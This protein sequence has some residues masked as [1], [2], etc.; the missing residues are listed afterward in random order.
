MLLFSLINRNAFT[1]SNDWLAC[2]SVMAG[3]QMF[4]AR[5]VVSSKLVFLREADH[6]NT[7][8]NLLREIYSIIKG[9]ADDALV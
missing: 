4:V 5:T 8:S 6:V 9:M 2:V 7:A 1:N 3:Y